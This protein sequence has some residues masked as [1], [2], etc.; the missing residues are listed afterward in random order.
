LPHPKAPAVQFQPA[1]K[2][3]LPGGK[4]LD[5]C[6]RLPENLDHSGPIELPGD[7]MKNVIAKFHFGCW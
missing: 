2:D 7:K 5:F 3:E 6:Q 1:R 4:Q